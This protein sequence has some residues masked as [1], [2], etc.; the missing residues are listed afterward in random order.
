[1]IIVLTMC[2]GKMG[3]VTLSVQFFMV[4]CH[5]H[6]HCRPSLLLKLPTFVEVKHT[7]ISTGVLNGCWK[8]LLTD[9]TVQRK[10]R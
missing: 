9:R 10:A 1:M 7:A 2:V 4:M 5:C 3:R 6:V 8:K